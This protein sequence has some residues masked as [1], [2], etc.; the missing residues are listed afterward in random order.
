MK[1]KHKKYLIEQLNY[2]QKSID[3]YIIRKANL[4]DTL[5]VLAAIL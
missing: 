4:T 5:N 2:F 3:N 1:D